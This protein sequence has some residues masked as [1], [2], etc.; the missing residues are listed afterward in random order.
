LPTAAA[1]AAAAAASEA[2]EAEFVQEEWIEII[3]IQLRRQ[4]G[5]C[6]AKRVDPFEG[7][8][9]QPIIRSIAQ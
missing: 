3:T 4:G 7:P 8:R 9:V 2:T 5:G 6:E 1:A